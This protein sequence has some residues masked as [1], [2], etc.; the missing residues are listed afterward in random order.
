[1]ST[2]AYFQNTIE[3][4]KVPSPTLTL[5]PVLEDKPSNTA[6]TV[7]AD[8][9]TQLT[10][11][12]RKMVSQFSEQIDLTN[13]NMIIQYGAGAQKKIA[14]FSDQALK[15][16]QTRNLDEVGE[17]L[18]K[19]VVEL[20]DLNLEEKES[21]FGKM[22][23][24]GKNR[25]E[26][27]KAKYASAESNIN[28]IVSSLESHQIQLLK[29]IEILEQMYQTNLSYFK[30]LS[31]YILAGKEKIRT[32][33]T[34]EL[35]E[36]IRKSE[37]SGLPEDIHAANDFA[38]MIDRFEKRI[39]DLELTRTVAMQLAPQIRLLQNNDALMD[40]KIQSSLVNTIPLWK[41]QMVLALGLAHASE[42]AKAQQAVTEMTNRLLKK[43]A[44]Q[45]KLNSIEIARE[46]EKGIVDIETL[47]N[48]NN[49]LIETFDE[50]LKIQEDGRKK[51][52][53][54]ESELL[55]IENDLKQKLLAI[56]KNST[57]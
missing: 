32:A 49:S 43:N 35:P 57:T 45:L 21:F 29:D 46:S 17:M 34:V 1:M 50:V 14:D 5:N 2:D 12:E 28:I 51:R 7:N 37:I 31:M 20:K 52:Q 33:R 3:E 36:L 24:K 26:S 10:P 40:E 18:S 44:E 22:F 47:K 9:E 30:E 13:T 6:E 23:N 15:K 48:T 42:A 19:M 41:N 54:A 38:G 11:E 8:F 56:S 27:I 25:I 39:H 55:Q 16:V 53:E 4:N